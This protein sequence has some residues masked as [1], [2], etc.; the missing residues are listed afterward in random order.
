MGT[1][2]GFVEVSVMSIVIGNAMGSVMRSTTGSVVRSVMDIGPS[3]AGGTNT[4]SDI[5]NFMGELC[6]FTGLVVRNLIPFQ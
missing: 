6:E 1:V 4:F 3:G 5:S 2:M